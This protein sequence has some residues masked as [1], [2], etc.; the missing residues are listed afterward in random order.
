MT[1][2]F[3]A[4]I[5]RIN[6]IVQTI[7]DPDAQRCAGQ[8]NRPYAQR[9]DL[10]DVDRYLDRIGLDK[11]LAT[12]DLDGLTELHL[13]HLAAVPFENLDI[14]FGSGV[15]HDPVLAYDK[16]VRRNRGGWCFELNGSF[17][18]LLEAVGFD[19]VLLGAAV[20]LDGPNTVIEHLALE[21]SGGPGRL[22][23]HLVDVGFGDSFDLPLAV[24]RSGPQNGGSAT[25]EFFASPKG[26]TLSEYVDGVP[27]ARFRFKRV[28]HN[29]ADFATVA[30]SMQIDPLK[31]WSSKPFA[32]RLLDTES[33]D[34]VT[35]TADHLKIRRN[36]EWTE[37]VTTPDRFEHL[38]NEWFAISGPHA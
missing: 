10:A 28:A 34:R 1:A 3:R 31:H 12:S 5:G 19:V 11:A 22:E 13:A 21:V 9:V 37:Q 7:V 18:R 14:V 30:R 35:L 4:V 6:F 16:I 29:F 38:L 8:S 36:G 2:T 26:T 33:F 20:L 15:P 27:E 17:A 24:N 32:T 23:P 25:F